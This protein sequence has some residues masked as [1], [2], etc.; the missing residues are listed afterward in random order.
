[1]RPHRSPSRP[2]IKAPTAVEIAFELNAASSPTIA[3][4]MCSAD[5]HSASPDAPAT[6]DPASM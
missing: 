1:L 2:P 6:I 3:L 4:F 5:C